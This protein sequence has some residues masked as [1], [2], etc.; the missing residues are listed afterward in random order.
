MARTAEIARK[1]GE[2]DIQGR[3]NIDGTGKGDIDT[4]IGFLDHM[5]TQLAHHSMMDITLKAQGDLHIDDHHTTEDTGLALGNALNQALG[6]RTGINRYAEC[7]LAM[8]EALSRV[9]IDVSGRPYLVWNVRL[10]AMK[11]GTMET[12]LFKEWF[13]AFANSARL[14]LH[15]HNE[16]G[17]NTHHIIESCFKGLARALRQACEIDP[18]GS[19]RLPSTKGVL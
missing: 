17:E 5:L 16:Y 7:A 14:T 4:G 3:L 12:E 18:R 13:V 19:E 8:D 15:V 1:T 11:L 2:T 9:T 10:P 6:A